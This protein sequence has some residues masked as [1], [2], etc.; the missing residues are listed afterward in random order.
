MKTGLTI[1]KDDIAIDNVSLNNVAI[2]KSICDGPSISKL[3]V[4]FETVAPR[5]N[6][7]GTRVYV[8]P[9]SYSV[10]KFTYIKARYALGI[11]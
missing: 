11:R 8:T 6:I 4:L 2:L 9:V 5:R 10:A 3:E 1:E 7:V